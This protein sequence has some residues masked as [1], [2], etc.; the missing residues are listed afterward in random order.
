VHFLV[1]EQFV[2]HRFI[3]GTLFQLLSCNFPLKL[4]DEFSP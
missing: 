1:S 2:E 3:I 4:Y